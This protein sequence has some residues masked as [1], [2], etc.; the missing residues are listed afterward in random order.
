M[1]KNMEKKQ[2]SQGNVGFFTRTYHKRKHD[3]EDILGRKLTKQE[4]EKLQN[5]VLKS[6]ALRFVAGIGATFMLGSAVYKLGEGS[7]RIEGVSQDENSNVIVDTSELE[8]GTNLH[9]QGQ[10]DREM[11]VNGLKIDIGS[12]EE[13]ANENAMKEAEQ[14]KREEMIQQIKNDIAGFQTKEDVLNYMKNLYKTEYNKETGQMLNDFGIIFTQDGTI[15]T[16]DSETNSII[17]QVSNGTNV[18]SDNTWYRATENSEVLLNLYGPMQQLENLRKEYNRESGK[19]YL[20][21]HVDPEVVNS[22]VQYYDNQQEKANESQGMEIG[23]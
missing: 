23:D 3:L 7:G 19:E 10:S 11:F 9:V 17:E 6:Y 22:L 18:K 20:A 12:I 21:T 16:I 13:Q 1:E 8:N 15:K 14:Q 4:S 5:K 2:K